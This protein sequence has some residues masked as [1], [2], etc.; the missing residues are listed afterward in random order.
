[1]SV[2]ADKSLSWETD[3]RRWEVHLELNG[4]SGF[5]DNVGMAKTRSSPRNPL[6]ILGHGEPL[7]KLARGV[8]FECL[9]MLKW[10]S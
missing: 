2:L 9:T 4:S 10:I 3:P 1:M 5:F 6:L 8:G 7:E